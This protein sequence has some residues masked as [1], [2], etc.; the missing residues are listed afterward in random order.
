MGYNF[1][2]IYQGSDVR[3]IQAYNQDPTN[4]YSI[5]HGH[6]LVEFGKYIGQ[7][8]DTVAKYKNFDEISIDGACQDVYSFDTGDWDSF[9]NGGLFDITL[10]GYKYENV[11]LYV[12]PLYGYEYVGDETICYRHYRKML[13]DGLW[14]SYRSMGQWLKIESE[15]PM[16][17]MSFN[18]MFIPYLLDAYNYYYVFKD[19]YNPFGSPST[20]NDKLELYEYRKPEDTRK[21][22][23]CCLKALC[24][25]NEYK[26]N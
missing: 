15:F 5:Q 2:Q 16:A 8:Y 23:T 17:Y 4:F 18:N 11:I 22:T 6:Y 19:G 9:A 3:I 20:I 7:T 1:S 21:I 26:L 10:K 12:V 14:Y 13:S 25:P 24:Y